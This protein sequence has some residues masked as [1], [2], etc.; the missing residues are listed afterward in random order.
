M[1]KKF[2]DALKIIFQMHHASTLMEAFEVWFVFRRNEYVCITRADKGKC[3]SLIIPEFEK[4][5]GVR[6]SFMNWKRFWWAAVFNHN[7]NV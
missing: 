1:I 5:G 3:A 4:V 6:T 2:K 7:L